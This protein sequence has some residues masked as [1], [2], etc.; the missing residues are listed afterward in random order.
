MRAL[1]EEVSRCFPREELTISLSTAES[2]ANGGVGG[3]EKHLL[4][5]AGFFQNFLTSANV[6]SLSPSLSLS[7]TLSLSI[8]LPSSLS[9]L[10]L[11]I[12]ISHSLSHFLP[13][14][15]PLPSNSFPS[16]SL[17][18][19]LFLSPSY[20][21]LVSV[22][23]FHNFISITILSLSSYLL[24]CNTF[25]YL[26]ILHLFSFSPFFSSIHYS[27]CNVTVSNLRRNARSLSKPQT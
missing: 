20:L 25:S 13:L 7:H 11:S 22:S 9:P 18:F 10:P 4:Y 27:P 19:S 1:S 6:S 26:Y 2:R 14:S 24:I 16:Y 3:L 8:F 5:S 12:S 15:Y 21:S 23:K 17:S